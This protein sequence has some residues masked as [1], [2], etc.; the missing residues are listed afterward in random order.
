MLVKRPPGLKCGKVVTTI[1]KNKDVQYIHTHN[2]EVYKGKLDSRNRFA[3]VFSGKL[4]RHALY[5][6][7]PGTFR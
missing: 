2:D 7:I 4:V 3:R 6:E 5:Q 1:R